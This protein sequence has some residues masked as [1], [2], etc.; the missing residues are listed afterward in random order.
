MPKFR[1]IDLFAGIGGFHI[2]LDSLG[3]ECVFASEIDAKAQRIYKLNF[4]AD[5]MN[6]PIEGDIIPLTDPGV[7]PLIPGHDLLAAGFPCQPFSKSGLQRGINETRGTLFYNIAKVLES[8]EPRFVLLEN[9]RNL[10][11]PRHRHT[12]SLIIRTLR[13]LG[14]RVSDTPTIFSP[15]LLP[16]DRGGSPQLRDRVYIFGHFVGAEKAWELADNSFQLPYE[17]VGGWDIQKWNLDEHLL[18]ADTDISE[19]SKYKISPER[20]FAIDVWDDFLRVV[21]HES[22][23]RRLPGFP[24]WEFALTSEPQLSPDLPDWKIDF[25]KKNSAFYNLNKSSIDSWRKRHPK[26]QEMPVSFRK[27]EWQA[28]NLPSL[29]DAAIQF[30][31]SGLRVKRPDYLPALVAMNQTSIVGKRRRKITV[32][33]AARLQTFPEWF[34]FGDQPDS[35]SYRQL[36]NAVSTGVVSYILEEFLTITGQS[37]DNDF[38]R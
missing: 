9:V 11:G 38:E 37:L 3:G 14:Y 32:R 34:E 24:I 4:G 7:S 25:L 36:G 8:H 13:D 12:W 5:K 27:L 29:W 2:A 22:V 26:I 6:G 18:Q 21:N 30:R 31:P 23:T 16:P 1:Y 28:G 35:D 33:E 15:H 19:I 20:A 17:P 10:T